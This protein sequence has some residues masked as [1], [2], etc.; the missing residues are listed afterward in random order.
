MMHELRS[1]KDARIPVPSAGPYVRLLHALR[2]DPAV[3]RVVRDQRRGGHRVDMARP[4]GFGLLPPDRR[5]RSAIP[6]I[7]VRA[8]LMRRGHG[9]HAMER[10]TAAADRSLTAL[11]LR[12]DPYVAGG[13]DIDHLIRFY[14]THGFVEMG[15][16]YMVRT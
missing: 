2:N 14:E 13:M 1:A 15:D 7:S 6:V 3:S 8:A 10:L 16:R 5:W 12:A 11:V 4:A 9:G